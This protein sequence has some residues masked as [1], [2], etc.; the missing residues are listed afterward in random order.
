MK[1]DRLKSYLD[2]HPTELQSIKRDDALIVSSSTADFQEF[3]LR[4][5]KD[6]GAMTDQKSFVRP[7]DPATRPA[8]PAQ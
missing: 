8:K 3:V 1:Q 4:H 2:A 5:Y 6:D 7:G